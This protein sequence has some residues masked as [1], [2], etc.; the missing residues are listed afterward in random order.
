M[1]MNL[2]SVSNGLLDW[3]KNP[4]KRQFILLTGLVLVIMFYFR[5]CQKQDMLREE[6]KRQQLINE[7]NNR[8]LTDS[9]HYL[10]NREGDIEAIKSSFVSKLEDLEKLNAD[11]YK[12][13]KSEFGKVNSLIKGIVTID[14]GTVSMSNDLINYPD[15]ITHGLKF[16]HMR[17]DSGLTWSIKGESQF[18]FQNNTIFPGITT[19]SENQ[20]KL[21]L[22]MGFKTMDNGDYQVFARSGSPFVT[23]GELDGV[24]IIPKHNDELLCPPLKNKKFGL[25]FQI[26]YGIGFNDKILLSPYIGV[27]LSYNLIN[28]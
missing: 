25:G 7:Q 27:G 28:F 15:G 14:P 24:L 11:L 10:K 8:A 4:N 19:I 26:G 3:I 17:I 18:K 23:F 20:M 12:E 13:V 9:V 22:V 5:S 2:S 6:M 16:E 1:K 21:N